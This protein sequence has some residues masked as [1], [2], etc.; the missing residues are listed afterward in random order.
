ML[1]LD[2][3][4]WFTR[5][6][7]SMVVH[8]SVDSFYVGSGVMGQVAVIVAAVG[9]CIMAQAQPVVCRIVFAQWF[10]VACVVP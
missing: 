2:T 3:C 6:V 7:T 5:L 4:S 9:A 1:A 8:F 10:A